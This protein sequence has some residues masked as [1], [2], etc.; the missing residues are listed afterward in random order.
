[1]QVLERDPVAVIRNWGRFMTEV[2]P[3]TAPILL[4]MRTAARSDPLLA[5]VLEEADRAA[6]ERMELNA[7]RLLETGGLRPGITVKEVRDVLWTYSSPELYDL[8][9]LR[10]RWSL[11]RYADFAAGGMIAALL[12][13]FPERS[14]PTGVQRVSPSRSGARRRPR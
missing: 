3:R 12:A 7:R 10:R 14:D 1:M 6:L 9:V 8:L 13:D 5:R 11:K 4:L 2:A